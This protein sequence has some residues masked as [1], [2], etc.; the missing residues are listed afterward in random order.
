MPANKFRFVSP[1]IFLS[2]IDQSQLPAQV[3]AV[4][5]VII[6]RAEHGPGMIPTKIRSFS[7]FVETF[8]NPSSG[9]GASADV[10]RE[11]NYSAPT[12]AAYAAQAYLRSGVGPITYMRLMGTA[13]PSANT[14]GLA[15]WETTN[16]PSTTAIGNGGPYGLFVFESGATGTTYEG[17]LAAVFYINT[18]ST[19]TLS[20]TTTQ[21]DLADEGVASIIRSDSSGQFKMRILQG[22]RG[23]A[24]E[25]ENQTFSLAENNDKFVRKVFNTNPQL[26]NTTIEG[27]SNDTPYWLGESFERYLNDKSF[28]TAAVRYGFLAPVA[29]GSSAYGNHER[30]MSYRDAHTG[31]FF[32]QHLSADTASFDYSNVQKL[33]KFIGINGHG[34]WLQN[35]TKISIDNIRASSNDNVPFG[36]F[37][38]V[39]RSARDSDLK[40]IVLERFSNCDLDPTSPNYIAVKIG[41]TYEEWDNTEKRYREFGS[42]PNVSRYIRVVMALSLIHI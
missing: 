28:D 32:G 33:F 36:T 3:D 5:P 11:G 7:E 8:G 30:R 35:N 1:G 13:H 23:G 12:Y 9:K 34:E 19:P 20:G 25:I 16:D 38:V 24:T 41:D 14:A 39:V 21:N 31:W 22:N 26:T 37:D 18:G 42:Y 17:T 6:G 4:G 40:P 29:S 27:A 2:E 10:W 15:G